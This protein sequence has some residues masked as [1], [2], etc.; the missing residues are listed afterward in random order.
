MARNVVRK[1]VKNAAAN[2]SNKLVNSPKP[3]SGKPKILPS[4]RAPTN[5]V[6][7]MA[8]FD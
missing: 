1:N 8:L 2:E 4:R 3:S 7:C 5:S 6:M